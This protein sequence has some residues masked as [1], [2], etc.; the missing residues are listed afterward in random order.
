MHCSTCTCIRNLSKKQASYHQKRYLA[1]QSTKHFSPNKTSITK[2][3]RFYRGTLF[4][5]HKISW[6]MSCTCKKKWCERKIT[7]PICSVV[8]ILKIHINFFQLQSE[9]LAIMYGNDR[10]FEIYAAEIMAWMA[11]VK[12]GIYKAFL[13][14]F[15]RF[16]PEKHFIKLKI[17]HGVKLWLYCHKMN[18]SW[19][20]KAAT[21][22]KTWPLKQWQCEWQLEP[23]QPPYMVFKNVPKKIW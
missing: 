1:L 6:Y 14:W 10:I 22:R 15:V 16:L 7:Q 17:S 18:S 4:P 9:T 21:T 3:L 13:L 12:Q 11:M 20:V 19:D 2:S 5:R 23:H 8:F